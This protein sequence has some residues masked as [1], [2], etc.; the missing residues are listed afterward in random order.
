[1]EAAGLVNV[2]VRNGCTVTVKP[3]GCKYCRAQLVSIEND[4]L[5][6]VVMDT[7]EAVNVNV[8]VFVCPVDHVNT[9]PPLVIE[10][11]VVMTVND[12][13]EVGRA[14]GLTVN[15]AV[16]LGYNVPNVV[17]GVI[18]KTSFVFNVT[19]VGETAANALPLPMKN[20]TKKQIKQ[21]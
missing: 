17:D 16:S 2:Q 7:E 9:V 11:P 12:I 21:I 6:A 14:F 18:I 8:F 19:V 4:T 3:D 15:T 10:P 5:P 20:K 1:M 13:A